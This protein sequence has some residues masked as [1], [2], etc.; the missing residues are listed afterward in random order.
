MNCT[1][2]SVPPEG[3]NGEGEEGLPSD[4]EDDGDDDDDE[5]Y[6]EIAFAMERR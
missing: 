2:S 6:D 1:V 5:R 3:C 4:G